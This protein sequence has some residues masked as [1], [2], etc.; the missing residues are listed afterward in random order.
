MTRPA[1]TTKAKSRKIGNTY[2]LTADELIG[3]SNLKIREAFQGVARPFLRWNA[4]AVVRRT[5]NKGDL[6]CREGDFGRT[7]FMVE[8]GSVEVLLATSLKHAVKEPKAQT[9]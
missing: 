6:I 8:K 9:S 5:F 1:P 2:Y 7:A 3:H 4:R